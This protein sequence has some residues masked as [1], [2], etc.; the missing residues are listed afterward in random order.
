MKLN[1]P[2]ILQLWWR[3]YHSSSALWSIEL[4]ISDMEESTITLT[5]LLWELSATKKGNAIQCSLDTLGKHG[6][7]K[8]LSNSRELNVRNFEELFCSSRQIEVKGI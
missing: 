2:S 4:Y 8:G 5:K 1:K 6:L 3:N 7:I